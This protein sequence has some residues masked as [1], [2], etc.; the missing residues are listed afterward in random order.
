[1]KLL[2]NCYE[3]L[4]QNGKVIILDMIMPEEPDS[5]EATK[6]LSIVDNVMLIQLEGKERTEQ[7]I[8][9]LCKKSGFSSFKIVSRVLSVHGVMEFYK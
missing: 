6:F 4:P 8:E 5:S 7:E 1:V 3:A 9:K 2:R